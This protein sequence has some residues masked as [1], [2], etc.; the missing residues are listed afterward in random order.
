[1]EEETGKM[2]AVPL[3]G[4]VSVCLCLSRSRVNHRAG[5]PSGCLILVCVE[6]LIRPTTVP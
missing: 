3:P 4:D 5:F 1:M 2:L 6:G